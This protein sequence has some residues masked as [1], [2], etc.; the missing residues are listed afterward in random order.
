MLKSCE[1][2]NNEISQSISATALLKIYIN[3]NFF[4]YSFI[5]IHGNFARNMLK[6]R[7]EEYKKL[8]EG[9]TI[10]HGTFRHICAAPFLLSI[11][12]SLTISKREDE[13]RWGCSI[14]SSPGALEVQWNETIFDGITWANPFSFPP[15]TATTVPLAL[16]RDRSSNVVAY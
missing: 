12:M 10:F 15:T 14:M 9:S 3:N 5:D 4:F 13:P 7:N 11:W 1:G 8:Y 2:W 16:G 6:L